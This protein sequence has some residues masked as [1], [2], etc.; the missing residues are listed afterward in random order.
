MTGDT[1]PS[2]GQPGTVTG[3][4]DLPAPVVTADAAPAVA[5]TPL[6]MPTVKAA[7]VMSL[8][9]FMVLLWLVLPIDA[10]P[11]TTGPLALGADSQRSNHRRLNL[12]SHHSLHGCKL[13][14]LHLVRL[15]LVPT[16]E[17]PWEH[18][19]AEEA[20][21]DRVPDSEQYVH[22]REEQHH[23]GV[24]SDLCVGVLV[25]LRPDKDSAGSTDEA[26]GR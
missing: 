1:L 21:D 4:S 25:L 5:M 7:S 14:S 15:T 9:I 20:E 26:G 23:S 22:G 16:N 19:D 12:A 11:F 8:L 3:T 10:E 2:H 13:C 17:S 24:R 18:H 6:S